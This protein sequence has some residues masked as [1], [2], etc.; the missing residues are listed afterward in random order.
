MVTKPGETW[1]TVRRVQGD[2]FGAYEMPKKT[3]IIREDVYPY[4]PPM[5]SN[6]CSCLSV[7]VVNNRAL[8]H[9]DI[10]S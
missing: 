1:L 10:D 3:V 8:Y 9:P 4:Q 5:P 7:Q 6:A 2:T